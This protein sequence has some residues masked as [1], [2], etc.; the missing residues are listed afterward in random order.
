MDEEERRAPPP[1]GP[2]RPLTGMSVDELEGYKAALVREIAR[3]DEALR[4]RRDVRSAAEALFRR[5]AP[6]PDDGP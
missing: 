1:A 4:Q 2:G 6:A 3:V 5:P